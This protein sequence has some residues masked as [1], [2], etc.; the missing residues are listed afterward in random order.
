M[1]MK[2]NSLIFCVVFFVSACCFMG[3]STVNSETYTRGAIQSSYV[4]SGY[5]PLITGNGRFGILKV[6][7]FTESRERNSKERQNLWL[8]YLPIACIGTYWDRPGWMLWGSDQG[9]YKSVGLDMAE[10]VRN[11]LK[12]SGLFRKVLGPNESGEA[13]YVIEGDVQELNYKTNPHLC[14][15]SIF[16]AP[17][18]GTVGLPM[19]NWEVDQKVKLQL[20]KLSGGRADVLWSKVF[21]TRAEGQMAA[22]Y[23]GNPMQFGYPYED[24][25][26]PVVDGLIAAL[27]E[28][29]EEITPK[30]VEKKTNSKQIEQEPVAVKVENRPQNKRAADA[31]SKGLRWAV[32]VGVSK[33]SDSRIPSLRYA[34]SDAKAFHAWLVSPAGGRYAPANVKLLTGAAATSAN[35]REALFDWLQKA[36]AEDQVTIYFAG[37]GSSDTPGSTD[38]LFLLPYDT[39]YAHV[40]STAFPMWD[41]ETALK[42][43]IKAKRVIVIADACHSAGVGACFDIARRAGR[44]MKVNPVSTG[45]HAL[46]SVSEGVCVISASDE[47]QLSQESM[48]WGGGHGVFTYYLLEGLKGGADYNKD[49]SV[50]LGELTSY[51]SQEVRRAT[52]NEQSPTVAGR[53]DPA[54]VIGK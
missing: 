4:A 52:K 31:I 20:K 39:D 53:Y 43:Y 30:V 44:G 11:E 9:A 25:F 17:F 49:S 12:A 40:S 6:D 24:A 13:D 7:S 14:G 10:V 8:A 26:K 38:N 50:N 5:D 1:F 28:N 51:I 2:S 27:P 34:E 35:I 47:N 16:L 23:G 15:V 54:L 42:R 37:H 19:G 29:L 46:S 33:Y 21:P 32:V 41:V 36:V 45:I 18:A 22:Y 48:N 3:C